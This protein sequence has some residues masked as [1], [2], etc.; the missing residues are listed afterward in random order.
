MSKLYKIRDRNGALLGYV[1]V[2]EGDDVLEKARSIL[3]NAAQFKEVLPLNPLWVLALMGVVVFT[4]AAT[5]N[6]V[7]GI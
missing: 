1:A 6:G 4:T 7:W 2:E 5:L 3:P